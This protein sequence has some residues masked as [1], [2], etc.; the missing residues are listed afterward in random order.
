MLILGLTKTTLLDYPGH[1]AATVFTGGCNFRCPYCHNGQMVLNPA[2]ME[3]ISEEEVLAFLKKRKG[4]LDGVCVTGGEPTIQSDLPEFIK[5][6]KDLGYPVKLDT[7]GTHPGMIK[8]LIAAGLVD[9][10]AMDIKN[11]FE[12]YEETSGCSATMIPSIK[13]SIKIIEESGINY[14][15]RTTVVKELH[16]PE[17]IAG[18]TALIKDPSRYFLQSYEESDNVIEKRFSAY[19]AQEF[20]KILSL[21]D[22]PKPNLRGIE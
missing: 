1:V 9:H 21:I 8:E 19:S 18:I 6:I 10:I 13:E 17:D 2:S 3:K 15:F 12:K 11:V 14:E 20:E 5:K 22:G 7:N 16:S 4:I